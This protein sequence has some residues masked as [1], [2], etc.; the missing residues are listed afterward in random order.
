M[1]QND[2][3]KAPIERAGEDLFDYAV[4]REDVKWLTARL[5]QEA[6]IKPS[7]VEYELQLLKIISVG[8]SLAYYLE[9]TPHKEPLSKIYWQSI[10]EFS[11]S[12]SDT[13]GL[14]IGQEIDYFQTLKD[15]LDLYVSALAKHPDAVEPATVIGPEF[16]KTC[17]NE[18]DLFAFM[19]GSKMFFSAIARVREYL[20]ALKLR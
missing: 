1:K 12:L 10:R 13:T 2:T 6:D 20:E 3:P 14:M 4:D 8:W 7:K 18:N 5:P 19:T 15:R 9:G 17:G 16:A 11:N